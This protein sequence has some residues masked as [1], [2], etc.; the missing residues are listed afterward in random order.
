MRRAFWVLCLVSIGLIIGCGGGGSSNSGGSSLPTVTKTS[1]YIETNMGNILIELFEQDAPITTANFIGLADGTKPWTDPNTGQQVTRPFYDG[2]TFHRV[3]PDFVI[4]GGDPL[5]N[6][7]G[8]PG[9]EFDDEISPTL[10]FD[11]VGRVAMANKGPNT[12][13][14]QFFILESLSHPPAENKFSIFGQVTSGQDVV[15]AIAHVPRD[16][17][18]DDRPLTP[19]TMT[20][21]TITP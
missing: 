20:K 7:T 4:Q 15:T 18:N 16:S 9:Y 14:S 13:G 5:G 21:V 11:Q 17:S 3:V 6:G 12:N 1:A 2:L 8:G 19:V 10:R